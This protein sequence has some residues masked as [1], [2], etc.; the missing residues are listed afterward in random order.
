M[1][2]PPPAACQASTPQTAMPPSSTATWITSGWNTALI[3]S[4]V[5]RSKRCSRYSETLMSCSPRNTGTKTSITTII[6]NDSTSSYCSQ[7]RPPPGTR[8]TSAGI[9]MKELAADCVARIDSASAQ[10]GSLRPPT[11]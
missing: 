6:A 7:A 3:T 5:A 8:A 1:A 4:L 2:A 10:A 11:W 9:P